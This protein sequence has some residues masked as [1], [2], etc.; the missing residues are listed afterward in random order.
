M[1][2]V[3]LHIRDVEGHKKTGSVEARLEAMEQL[4]FKCQGMVERGLNANHM[5]ITEFT[6]KHKIDANDIGKHLS[7]LYDRIDHLQAQIYDLQNKNYPVDDQDAEERGESSLPNDANIDSCKDLDG[8]LMK[9]AAHDGHNDELVSLYDK[10]NHVVEVGKLFPSMKEFRMCLKTYAVKHEFDSNT[11]WTDR[12]K[13]YAKCRGFDGSVRPCKWRKHG[14][15]PLVV[16]DCWA[17]NKARI[18]GCRKKRSFGRSVQDEPNSDDV[19]VQNERN[20]DDVG[21]QNE[22]HSDEVHNEQDLD[23]G[24]NEK[25]EQN[26]VQ[27]RTEVDVANVET[28]PIMEVVLQTEAVVVD[29]VQSK[30]HLDVVMPTKVVLDGLVKKTKRLSELGVVPVLGSTSAKKNKKKS[31]GKKK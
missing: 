2:E 30:P 21:V 25:N 1:R 20:L 4:V 26:V 31:S 29:V 17:T 24:Q 5:M 19:V 3:V 13:F 10:E 6:N 11:I 22:Q 28:E 14:G 12:K 9:D 23:V 16:E 27:T 8:Q 18:N 7:R 15:Q